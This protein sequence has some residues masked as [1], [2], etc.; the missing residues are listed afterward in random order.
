MVNYMAGSLSN[1]MC[2]LSL[3][4]FQTQLI[5]ILINLEFCR[6]LRRNK[7]LNELGVDELWGSIHFGKLI[8]QKI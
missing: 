6:L 3:I 7:L 1:I 8:V 4:V 5:K 2:R